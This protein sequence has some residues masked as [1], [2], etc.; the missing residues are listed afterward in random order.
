[1]VLSLAEA[2]GTRP[3]I[4][5]R[6][7]TGIRRRST[8][9]QLLL[10]GARLHHLRTEEEALRILR[11]AADEGRTVA[12]VPRRRTE[13]RRRPIT[14]GAEAAGVAAGRVADTPE[15]E[16]AHTLAVAVEATPEAVDAPV[17]I[18]KKKRR[19][20]MKT[21]PDIG[22]LF[23][24]VSRL[25]GFQKYTG[26]EFPLTANL[27]DGRRKI[28]NRKD[29]KGEQR[30]PRGSD[31]PGICVRGETHRPYC[32]ALLRRTGEG[33]CPYTHGKMSHEH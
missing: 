1:M 28:S 7:A 12:A 30:P 21:P 15:A 9:T 29:R 26:Y 16:A 3:A 11:T 13:R 5:H 6:R 33:A 25:R 23:C 31:L 24:V 19:W 14:V 4:A 20:L 2:T 22:R 18:A 32:G 27:S 8:G 17:V 10:I